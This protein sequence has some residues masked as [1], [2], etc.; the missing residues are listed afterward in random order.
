MLI[1]PSR[2][3]FYAL[4]AVIFI[5]YNGLSDPISSHDLA[6]RQGLP[7]RYLEQLMQ[8]LVRGGIL[9]GIRGPR[10]GY[11]LARERRRIT[12]GDICTLLRDEEDSPL[13]FGTPLGQTLLKPLWDNA[14]ER[15]LGQLHDLNIAD[16]CEQ[17]ARSNI[18]KSAEEKVDFTI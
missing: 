12:V 14:S 8:K 18:L 15:A 5:A 10:G 6:T 4:E 7:K 9:R 2:K 16:L 3:L 17:A 13:A 1:T 11:L